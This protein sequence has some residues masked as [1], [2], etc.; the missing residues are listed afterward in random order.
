L[1]IA[2]KDKWRYRIKHMKRFANWYS[3]RWQLPL[4]YAAIALVATL[5]LGV[6]LLTLLRGYYAGIERDAMARNAEFLA[7]VIARQADDS[8]GFDESHAEQISNLA[9]FLDIRIEILDADEQVVVD[10]GLAE[11]AK[12]GLV[13]DGNATFFFR[14]NVPG[15][16]Q[17]GAVSG[18]TNAPDASIHRVCI[19]NRGRGYRL[20][21]ISHR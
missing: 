11:N 2:K 16:D 20:L 1:I 17:E 14:V 10:S 9:T 13:A 6:V 19:S 15:E 4:S 3:I 5:T 12:L 7:E 21:P 8:P 18:A